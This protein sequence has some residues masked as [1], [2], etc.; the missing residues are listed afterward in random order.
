MG[1]YPV[2]PKYEPLWHAME[3]TGIVYG[4][5][6]FPAIGGQVPAGYSE[7]YSPSQLIQRT[8]ATSGVPHTFLG[9]MQAFMAEASFSVTLT[10]MSGFFSRHPNHKPTRCDV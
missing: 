9:N 6:P 7:Q 4:M 1:N 5:H 10:F 8:I 2:Q 3:E